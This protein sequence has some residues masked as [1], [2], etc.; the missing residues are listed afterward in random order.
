MKYQEGLDST[1][2]WLKSHSKVEISDVLE[3]AGLSETKAKMILLTYCEE[4]SRLHASEKLNM[5]ESSYSH[6]M[7]QALVKVKS[8]LRWLG[9]ID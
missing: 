1:K 3:R 6:K 2:N 5:C 9:L 7:T 4:K 8:A